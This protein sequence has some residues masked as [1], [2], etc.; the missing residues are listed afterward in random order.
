[1][2]SSLN[3]EQ[4]A[5]VSFFESTIRLVGGLL[6]AFELSKEPTF[7]QKAQQMTDK[8]MIACKDGFGELSTPFLSI[9]TQFKGGCR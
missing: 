1:M 6:S 7:L 8:L 5:I 9:E 2:A 4:V 3:L